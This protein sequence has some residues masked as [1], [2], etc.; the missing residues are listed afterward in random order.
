MRV[1]D[2]YVYDSKD[3]TNIHDYKLGDIV[4]AEIG[5]FMRVIDKEDCTIH[6]QRI[7]VIPDPENYLS[8]I[9]WEN[10][11][12]NMLLDLICDADCKEEKTLYV[13]LMKY[14]KERYTYESFKERL[15]DIRKLYE[16]Q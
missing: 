13:T 9:S 10:A 15:E 12:N 11:T 4:E 16:E 1:Q 7:A 8:R 3:F 14:I 5:V 6:T 2:R